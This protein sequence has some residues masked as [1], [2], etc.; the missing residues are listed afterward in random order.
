M[1]SITLLDIG[2]THTR[3]AETDAAGLIRSVGVV[4]SALLSPDMLP[5][6]ECAA[7]SVN[8]AAAKRL[9]GCNVWFLDAASCRNMIDLDRM[10]CSTLGADRLANAVAA[11]ELGRLPAIV[12]DCGTAITLEIIDKKRAFRGGAI[13][14]GRSLMRRALANGTAQLPLTD[15]SK[16]GMLPGFNTADA[17]R[18]GVDSGA[19]GML[20]ELLQ[21]AMAANGFTAAETTVYIA[22]GDAPF[23]AA[24]FPEYR[25]APADFT[26]LGLLAVYRR[27]NG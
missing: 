17:I 18:F 27:C 14:P 15:L 25:P 4:D 21:R 23:F 16:S 7:V 10:D 8:P 11:A 1:M 12:A 3:I 6:G 2:N 5:H 19:I 26:L 20:R 22:G 24:G 13:A 9:H